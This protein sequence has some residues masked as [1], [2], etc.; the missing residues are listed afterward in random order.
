M[1]LHGTQT[2]S[3]FE[4]FRPSENVKSLKAFRCT[5][6]SSEISRYPFQDVKNDC[7]LES[8]MLKRIDS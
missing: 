3:P 7:L 4:T 2:Q 6:A 5:E 1:A 8:D